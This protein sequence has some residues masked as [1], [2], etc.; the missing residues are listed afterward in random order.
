MKY[1]PIKLYDMTNISE[2]LQ[3]ARIKAKTHNIDSPSGKDIVSK[4]ISPD[5]GEGYA[6]KSDTLVSR[7]GK[8]VPVLNGIPD[9]TVF[10]EN[11]LDEKDEQA[12]FHDDE[13]RNER[14]DEIVLRPFN[15]NNLHAKVWLGHL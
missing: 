8:P 7:S 1:N 10:S 13:E 11:A 4:L 2:G 9:F 6:L 3:K 14:F 5:T 12:S 15:Y